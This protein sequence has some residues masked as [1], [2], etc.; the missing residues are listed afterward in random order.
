MKRRTVLQ[1]VPALA[2]FGY[3]ARGTSSHAQDATPEA[4]TPSTTSAIPHIK[5]M[6][7]SIDSADDSITPSD[8]ALFTIQFFPDGRVGIKADCNVGGGSY[9]IDGENLTFEGLFT[10]L[11]F[12]GDESLDQQFMAS[13]LEVKTW[14]ISKDPGDQ[15]ALNLDADGARMLFNPALQ[16]VVWQWQEF[17]GGDGSVIAPEHPDRYTIEF[18]DDLSL[19]VRADCNSGRGSA[20]VD[21]S[22]IDILF[23][24]TKKMCEEG[25]LFNEYIRYLDEAVEYVIADGMLF[26]NLPMDGGGARFAPVPTGDEDLATPAA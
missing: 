26:L 14:S 4:G 23:G 2:T 17:L 19:H 9:V 16:G 7:A 18:F 6:L 13:L 11:A 21:G 10:T 8:P 20:T 5:W 12:C 3:F 1:G 22:Q 24:M 15:L 25:S